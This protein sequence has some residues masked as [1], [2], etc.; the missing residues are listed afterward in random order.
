MPRIEPADAADLPLPLQ[1]QLERGLETR[2]LS[3]TLP[4]RIWARRPA[5]AA[6][7]LKT[8]A[9][10]HEHGV[11]DARLRELVRLKVASVT[12][13]VACKVARKSDAVSEEDVLACGDVEDARFS[14]AEQAALKF[15]GLLAG[16][17]MEIDDG[18]FEELR[19]H[20][21]D[22]EIVELHLFC[23]LMLAGGRVTYA[24]RGYET[25]EPGDGAP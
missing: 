23:G 22:E 24:L 16:N 5:L 18:V 12:N 8:L 19:A 2:M 13:C 7:W 21:S 3:T 17:H 25:S 20:F 11:L 15:A 14:P 6:A 4:V 1:A 10:I 9:E